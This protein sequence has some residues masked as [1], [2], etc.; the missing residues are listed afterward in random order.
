[1][2][3]A[4]YESGM[5]NSPLYDGD[6]FNNRSVPFNGAGPHQMELH[7]VGFSSLFAMEA[8]YLDK[9]YQEL[10]KSGASFA[11]GIVSPPVWA[12][13]FAALRNDIA[14]NLWSSEEQLWIDTFT[15][16]NSF[17]TRGA[18]YAPDS[19]YPLIIGAATDAQA[20]AVVSKWLLSPNHFC[21]AD[22]PF[23]G[24][25]KD[26]Y[27]GLPSV[28]RNSTQFLRGATYWRGNTWGPTSGIVSWS[29]EEY[30]HVPAVKRGRAA[31]AEQMRQMFLS[32]WNANRKVCETYCVQNTGPVV[33]CCGDHFYVWGAMAGVL[34]VDVAGL[35]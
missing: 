27:W 29:L 10:T 21:V 1:M 22:P 14:T 32:L 9:M 6:L 26:C 35:Y 24:L 4:R 3:A 30:E 12:A 31:L 7:S 17:Y 5:D 34:A 15:K 11:P 18:R 20:S 13:R 19:F 23:A 28:Q 2:Q 16:N 8:K 25:H 33:S